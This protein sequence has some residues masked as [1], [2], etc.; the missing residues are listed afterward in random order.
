MTLFFTLL[1]PSA[2]I[3]PPQGFAG[4]V[5]WLLLLSGIL[6]LTW[7]GRGYNKP[8]G[9]KR[10]LLTILIVFMVVTNLFIGIRLPNETGLPLPEIPKDPNATTI[11]PFSAISWMLVAGLFGPGWAGLVGFLSG[12]LQTLWDNHNPFF[13]LELTLLAILMG[14]AAQQRFRTRLYRLLR[15]PLFMSILLAI[16]YPILALIDT[17]LMARGALVSR[18]DFALTHLGGVSL[19]MAVELLVAGMFTEVIALILPALWGQHGPLLPSPT[20]KS[21][22][23]RFQYTI[24]SLAALLI[25]ALIAG[26]W[27]VAGNAARS[28]VQARM[29]NSAEMAAQSLPY[30]FESGHNLITQFA[31]DPR[32]QNNSTGSLRTILEQQIKTIPFFRQIYVLDMNGNSL[33]GYP[34]ND[35][36]PSSA[37]PEEQTGIQQALNGFPVQYFA[38]PP[39]VDGTSAQVTFIALIPVSGKDKSADSWGVLIGRSDLDSNPITKP[40]LDNLNNLED[41]KGQ[42]LLLDDNGRILYHPDSSRIMEVY[43]AL[44]NYPSSS[45]G[46]GTGTEISENGSFF[47]EPAPNGT[48]QMVYF[49]P[50]AGYPWSIVLRVPA[51]AAQQ[52]ALAIATPLLGMILI[53]ALIA[54]LVM[55]F[56]LR[57]VTAS[58]IHLT[59]ET[60]QITQGRLDNPLPVDG[61]DEV[62]QLR[63]AFEQ[64][65]VRLKARLEE[66]NRLLTVSQGVASSLEISQAI[67]PV[68]EAALV[69][70]YGETGA[71]AAR[72]ILTDPQ[73]ESNYLLRGYPE[74]IQKEAASSHFSTREGE[75]SLS[76]GAAGLSNRVWPISFGLGAARD[77]YRD[78]DDQILALT[79]QQDRLVLSNLNRPRLLTFT[80][81]APRP[82]SL[83]A[84]ALRHENQYYGAL[85]VAYDRLHSF[86]EEEVRFLVTIA[87]QAAL[88]AAN[89]RLFMNAEIGRQRLAAILASSPDPVLVTDEQDH[90]LLAN[91]AAWQVLNLDIELPVSS[92]L[93]E[94]ESIEGEGQPIETIIQQKELL[95]LLRSTLDEKQSAEITLPD[96]QVYLANASPVM[97]EG[98]RMGRVCVLRDVTNFKKLESLKSDFV[99]TV[100]H[101]LRSPLSLMRGYGTMLE[102][103][104]SLNEQ[105]VGYVRKIIAGV[106]DMSRLVSS[107]LDLGR[108]EAGIGLE[109]EIVPVQDVVERVVGALQLQ[110]AQKRIQLDVEI[111]DQTIPLIEAD[112]ALL[113]QALQNLVENAIKYSRPEG[114]ITVRVHTRQEGTIFEVID[115]GPGISP[116]D[117]ARV[118]EKFYRGAQQA[119]EVDGTSR[120]KDQRGSGLG[121]AI[122]KSIAEQ[123]GGRVWLES[124]LGKGSTFYLS[125][126]LHQT[127]VKPES[128]SSQPK[129]S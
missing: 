124:Q 11:M 45:K 104:G 103:A 99:A 60:S 109:V 17:A 44:E 84:V 8:W 57:V 106:D 2:G 38:I 129:S 48:R 39:A 32:L 67:Q 41:I 116:M 62:G 47:D 119:R 5:G 3:E 29:A 59:N 100:S 42:S 52:I 70:Q 87:G 107:L 9:K 1:S 31:N 110:A 80:P 98:Q 43:S 68:L 108:I 22:A 14:I 55:R 78:L 79:R 81:Q 35:Y 82:E 36:L 91:P 113:Q 89:A 85:W 71:C 121:L 120:L 66:L 97:A 94:G 25:L 83:L 13:P 95:D 56:S 73:P 27:I 101:D 125:I 126:P 50:V 23:A 88:A 4:W 6:I 92:E 77:L 117:Q 40:I 65:R 12:T 123:H 75:K 24:G 15:H 20:E 114:K 102:M 18:L 96:G 21:L 128:T 122:V 72:I 74:P 37:P 26:D 34:E 127:G 33:A 86:S 61:E 53:L 10:V 51:Q 28:M 64:M 7:F 76:K 16:V 115:N 118:F 46:E 49:Q 93:V 63:R 19:A 105:Q 112:P 111:L 90:L 69:S 54:F 30:F 58:L